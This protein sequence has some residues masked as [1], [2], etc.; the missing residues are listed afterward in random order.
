MFYLHNIG[1]LS[2]IFFVFITLRTGARYIFVKML[3]IHSPD[4]I[5]QCFARQ[6]HCPPLGQHS[7]LV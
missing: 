7:S 6:A 1:E 4:L 3:K 2:L 5:G